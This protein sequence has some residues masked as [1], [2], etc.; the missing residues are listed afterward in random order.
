M[1]KADTCETQRQIAV[2]N[3]IYDTLKTG[4]SVVY[5]APCETAP[6]TLEAKTS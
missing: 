1:S 2:H 6:K 3:S 5:K 4:K